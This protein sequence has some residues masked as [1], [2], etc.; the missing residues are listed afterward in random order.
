MV[1]SVTLELTHSTIS[2]GFNTATHTQAHTH[3]LPRNVFFRV[4]ILL[5]SYG[6]R[7]RLLPYACSLQVH[8]PE[9]RGSELPIT[10][11]STSSTLH[12]PSFAAC[13]ILVFFFVLFF[14]I[15]PTRG[16]FFTFT[17]KCVQLKTSETRGFR[18]Y[19]L[20]FFF[21]ELILS[22]SY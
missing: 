16:G 10:L 12:M 13:Y 14:F 19:G 4:A 20:F 1:N 21:L 6:V 15:K 11:P 17:V 22:L 3:I 5:K 8:S 18:E 7:S 9:H 2:N